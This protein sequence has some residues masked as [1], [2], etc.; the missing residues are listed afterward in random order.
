M[1]FLETFSHL[2]VTPL[3]DAEKLEQLRALE[4]GYRIKV[5]EVMHDSIEVDTPQDIRRVEAMM[6]QPGVFEL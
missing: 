3:E 2:P 4:N 1:H 6:A 5:I